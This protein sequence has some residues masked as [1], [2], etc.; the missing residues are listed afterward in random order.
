MN[1]SMASVSTMQKLGYE[2]YAEVKEQFSWSESWGLVDGNQNSVNA[3]HEC[4]DRHTG[5]AY[6]IKSDDGSSEEYT[7]EAISREAARFAHHL[8][9][10]G[11]NEGDSVAVMLNP[12][13]EFVV[14]FFGAMKQGA[15]AVPCSELFGPQGLEARLEDADTEVLVTSDS[16]IESTDT[17]TVTHL[18]EQR[19]LLT[20]ITDYPKAYEATTEGQDEAWVLYTSGTTGRPTPVPFHHESIVLMAP[21]MELV[22]D[23]RKDDSWFTTSSPGFG[24]GI[25]YGLFGPFLYGVPSGHFSGQ[26]DSQIVLEAFDEFNVNTIA[27]AVPTALRKL[28]NK[29]NE[30]VDPPGVEKILYTGEPMDERLSREVTKILG[31]YPQS[32]YG[33][34]EIRSQITF[35]YGYPDYEFRHGSIGKPLP[36][37]EVK[38]VDEDHNELPLGELGHIAARR[39]NKWYYTKDQG[40]QDEDGYFY[41]AGRTDDTIISSGYT[42]GPQEVEDT[43]RT[44]ETVEEAGV[45]GVPDEVRGQLVKAYIEL[46]DGNKPSQDLK[47]ELQEYVKKEL[48]KYEYPRDIEFISTIPRTP[49]GKVQRVDLR[50]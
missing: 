31:A 1:S 16:V 5:V 15:V 7:F 18:I 48:G 45:I 33:V 8:D 17:S 37:I 28:V 49:D 27:G 3:T 30:M 41:A 13:F 43:L 21:T 44:H 40:Y 24:A 6:R 42:I 29:C 20:Q 22:L 32:V 23:I 10:L 39:G 12:S 50:S 2:T 25:W 14:A 19:N 46:K 4:I 34:T 35:D 11:I 9:E 47:E 38:I 36:G 26:F